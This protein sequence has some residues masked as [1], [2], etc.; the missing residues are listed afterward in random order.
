MTN[1]CGNPIPYSPARSKIAEK[2]NC[3]LVEYAQA[4]MA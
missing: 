1:E 4:M 3:T 2:L